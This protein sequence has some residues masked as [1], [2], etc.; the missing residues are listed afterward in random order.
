M[1]SDFLNNFQHA[2]G[3]TLADVRT[4]DIPSA[5]FSRLQYDRTLNTAIH[6]LHLLKKRHCLLYYEATCENVLHAVFQL[7]LLL[8]KA[9]QY[10]QIPL[11]LLLLQ[12]LHTYL[13]IQNVLP[14]QH[15]LD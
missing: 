4:P 12:I 14:M 8:Q 2:A 5:L 1:N 7:L 10:P 3:N 11:P 15:P 13:P 9:L 6:T